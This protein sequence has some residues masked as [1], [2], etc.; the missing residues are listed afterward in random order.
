MLVRTSRLVAALAF[1]SGL[2]VLPTAMPSA[3][4]DPITLV[5]KLVANPVGQTI[6]LV[7]DLGGGAYWVPTTGVRYVVTTVSDI[8]LGAPTLG[9]L[10]GVLQADGRS[11]LLTINN[12]IIVPVKDALGG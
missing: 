3:G 4:A 7:Q 9:D 1:T 5:Q 12:T 2:V 11:L 6:Y 10:V 8:V